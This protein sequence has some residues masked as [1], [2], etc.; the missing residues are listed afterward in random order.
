MVLMQ[1]IWSLK[2]KDSIELSSGRSI[3]LS[4]PFTL[5]YVCRDKDATFTQDL[6]SDVRSKSC[7]KGDHGSPV[8]SRSVSFAAHDKKTKSKKS[9]KKR[10]DGEKAERLS[11]RSLDAEYRPSTA[12]VIPINKRCS[13]Y[14]PRITEIKQIIPRGSTDNSLSNNTGGSTGDTGVASTELTIVDVDKHHI[15]TTAPIKP[16]GNDITNSASDSSVHLSLDKSLC[17]IQEDHAHI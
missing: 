9:L 8:S 7:M 10:R 2:Y 15:F 12:D 4:L 1:L 3:E 11:L 14:K 5:L 17:K 16:A 6:A 13:E